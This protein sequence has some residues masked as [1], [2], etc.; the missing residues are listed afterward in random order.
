MFW[1]VALAVALVCGL[2]YAVVSFGGARWGVSPDRLRLV[3]RSS[4]L[5]LGWAAVA[6]ANVLE[7]R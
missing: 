2:A 7:R 1:D 5:L 4:W 3:R 6:L